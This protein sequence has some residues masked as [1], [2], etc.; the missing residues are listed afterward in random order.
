[1]QHCTLDNALSDE[2][3]SPEKHGLKS[4]PCL[5]HSRKQQT[6]H[7]LKND[8]EELLESQI[9]DI[10]GSF[11]SCCIFD[12][13]VAPGRVETKI[14]DAA[15]YHNFFKL[16]PEKQMLLLLLSSASKGSVSN[17]PLY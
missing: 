7:R 2:S 12:R 5:H 11:V 4:N 16:I 13:S 3:T 10:I 8:S 1:M 14:G 6:F 17:H 15:G 9:L